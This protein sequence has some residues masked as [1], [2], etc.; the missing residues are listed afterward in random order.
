MPKK[1]FPDLTD[2]NT[3]SDALKEIKTPTNESAYDQIIT[4]VFIRAKK[5]QLLCGNYA[6]NK[7][8]I[9]EVAQKYK[10]KNIPDIKYTYDARR[11]RCHFMK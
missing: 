4:E 1:L 11:Y 2:T 7:E 6:F 8:L 9:E 3:P 10:I 5:N